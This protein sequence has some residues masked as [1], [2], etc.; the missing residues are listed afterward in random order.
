MSDQ[1]SDGHR[2]DLIT[3]NRTDG[4]YVWD[5]ETGKRLFGPFRSQ[6]DAERQIIHIKKDREK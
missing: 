2:T 5:S 3:I 4:W 1:N 6:S